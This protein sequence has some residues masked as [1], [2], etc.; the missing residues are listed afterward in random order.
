MPA[1]SHAH[2]ELIAQ[3]TTVFCWVGIALLPLSVWTDALAFPELEAKTIWIPYSIAF[4]CC[5]IGAAILH[6]TLGR[7]YAQAIS[8]AAVLSISLAIL[9]K[10]WLTGGTSSPQLPG[11]C[12]TLILCG[13]VLHW[14]W[15]LMALVT[16]VIA[17]ALIFPQAS[18]EQMTL[19]TLPQVMMLTFS[20]ACAIVA[21][22]VAESRRTVTER[23]HREL[24]SQ[25]KQVIE[26][27]AQAE[28]AHLQFQR[29][30]ST[31]IRLE[32]TLRDRLAEDLRQLQAPLK[33]LVQ[34][35]DRA[36]LDSLREIAQSVSVKAERLVTDF[37][38]GSASTGGSPHF[39]Q[40]WVTPTAE[41]STGQAARILVADDNP[42]MRAL[43][44]QVLSKDY[45]VTVV[46]DGA[47]AIEVLKSTP[48]DLVISD[49]VMPNCDGFEVLEAIRT[50]PELTH[51]AEVPVI[52]VTGKADVEDA[53]EG[54][55]KGA[56]DYIKKPFHPAVLQA[57]VRNQL[58]AIV[59]RERA[60]AQRGEELLN[61]LG[62]GLAHEIRNPLNGIIN[63]VSPLRATA[64]PDDDELLD[65]VDGCARRIANL[66]DD[67]LALARSRNL[68]RHPWSLNQSIKRAV[69]DLKVNS[70]GISV[71]IDTPE[72]IT[73][74]SQGGGL[75]QV[76]FNLLDNAMHACAPDGQIS[77]TAVEHS[78]EVEILITDNGEGIA[79]E[80]LSKIFD[81]FFTTRPPGQ[82]TGLGLTICRDIVGRHSGHLTLIS[83]QDTG[84]TAQ[85]RL[86][87][88]TLT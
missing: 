81:P 64:T 63:S 78:E 82:G 72:E 77:I 25:R 3:R 27:A 53:V 57:R 32:A 41:A 14:Q 56:N 1:L 49:I 87:L 54:L 12:V 11:L 6:T 9:A 68:P 5:I 24:V 80:A 47:K 4:A 34:A 50:S 30:M 26:S 17:T 88:P 73:L 48:A 66:C 42:V 74:L 59:G 55:T 36:G 13:I 23:Q 75:D 45:Q 60:M 18:Q 58:A 61:T 10:I 2:R 76:L 39:S 8:V 15:R 79:P 69:A 31:R 51:M 84:T 29:E 67:M 20:C 43:I 33:Q 46:A 86:R 40:A 62:A 21:A 35:T 85:I 44:T 71:L 16:T 37:A 7:R 65:V 83:D 19:T 22:A 70:S 38:G 28:A 52:L